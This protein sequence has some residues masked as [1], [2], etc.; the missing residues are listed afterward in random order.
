MMITVGDGEDDE[1]DLDVACVI[2]GFRGGGRS[3]VLTEGRM[4]G[5]S[6]L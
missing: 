2:S 1:D 4:Y 5:F 6:R 3:S